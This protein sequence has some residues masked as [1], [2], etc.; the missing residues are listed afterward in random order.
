MTPFEI[1]ELAILLWI[2]A[3]AGANAVDFARFKRHVL[4]VLNDRERAQVESN[5][6]ALIRERDKLPHGSRQHAKICTQL[7]RMGF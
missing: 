2:A 3:V 1:A 4:M 5:V 6:A 7:T